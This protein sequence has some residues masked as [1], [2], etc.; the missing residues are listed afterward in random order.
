MKTNFSIALTF[1]ALLLTGCG[2]GSNQAV[3]AEI[4]YGELADNA[5]TNDYFGVTVPVPE[6]W[7]AQDRQA[8]KEMEKLGGDVIAGDD[9]G[10]RATLDA[11]E[12]N[13][14]TLLSI[15]EHAVGA[16]VDFNPS[17][18]IVAEKVSQ[19]P[20]IKTGEDYIFHSKKLLEQA[21]IPYTFAKPNY[22]EE[23][24]GTTFRVL[25]A[26]ASMQG[27]DLTQRFYA[28]RIKDYMF[29]IVVS[30]TDDAQAKSLDDI[31]AGI[32]FN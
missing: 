30:H 8:I 2:D 15:F 6:D 19:F 3:V 21:A 32:T 25:E 29:V 11:A 1:F 23:V 14:L 28:T 18:N 26:K 22:D 4:G 27:L 16:P 12:Q 10:L 5:Y 13:T 31:L 24:G 20:G 9:D 7:H 17:V